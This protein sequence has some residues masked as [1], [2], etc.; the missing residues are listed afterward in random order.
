VAT[1]HFRKSEQTQHALAA[2]AAGEYSDD[3][4]AR[5]PPEVNPDPGKLVAEPTPAD[6]TRRSGLL[7]P[8][9]EI[10]ETESGQQHA[11]F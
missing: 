10:A 1:E 8:W 11:Q 7:T 9:R 3:L 4:D 2:V 5:Y 6:S